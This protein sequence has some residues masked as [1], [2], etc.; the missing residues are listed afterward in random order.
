MGSGGGGSVELSRRLPVPNKDFVR[1]LQIEIE[2][3]LDLPE[4]SGIRVQA[5]VTIF[6]R[7]TALLANPV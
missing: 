5:G 2:R 3:R 1:V 6:D 4:P 7:R